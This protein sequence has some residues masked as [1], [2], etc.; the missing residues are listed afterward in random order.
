MAKKTDKD[1]NKSK[2]NKNIVNI[3]DYKKKIAETITEN[4]DE[5]EFMVIVDLEESLAKKCLD[6][7]FP[8]GVP[9]EINSNFSYFIMG[10]RHQEDED[11]LDE[12]NEE[13]IEVT[14]E[15]EDFEGLYEEALIEL[16]QVTS[17]LE[18]AQ[19]EIALQKLHI[20]KIE[21]QLKKSKIK[22]IIKKD[23]K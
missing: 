19:Q 16:L 7:M 9:K 13:D 18:S 12:L 6:E 8:D 10:I 15:D 2:K 1:K 20:A 22:K 23:K 4:P 17:D 11:Q 3:Q 5:E 21:E 14:Y